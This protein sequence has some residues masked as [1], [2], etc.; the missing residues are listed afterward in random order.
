MISRRLKENIRKGSVSVC[1]AVVSNISRGPLI[2]DSNIT[3]TV[4]N[5][6]SFSLGRFYFIFFGSFVV[7]LCRWRF[8]TK[9]YSNISPAHTPPCDY[10]WPSYILQE[11]FSSPYRWWQARWRGKNTY[12][13]PFQPY[14]FICSESNSNWFTSYHHYCWWW[15]WVVSYFGTCDDS[16]ISLQIM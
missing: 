16:Y 15:L 3:V 7:T 9:P 1:V 2:A 14:R 11:V 13:W 5:G 4:M 12:L 8:S 6:S 10:N